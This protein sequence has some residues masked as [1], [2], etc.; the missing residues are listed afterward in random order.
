MGRPVHAGSRRRDVG[1]YR[2]AMAARLVLRADVPAAELALARA[3]R[4]DPMTAWLTGVEDPAAREAVARF[5]F[6][7]PGLAA[8]F[9][10]GH[11][12]V[13]AGEEATEPAGDPVLGG[14]AVWSPP[15]VELFG[16]AEGAAFA[17]AL[18]AACGESA[19]ERLMALAVAPL[20]P[21][22]VGC[23]GPR[24]RCGQRAAPAGARTLRRRRPPRIPRIVERSQRVILRAPRVPG[25]VGGGARRRPDAARHVARAG[26]RSRVTAAAEGFGNTQWGTLVVPAARHSRLERPWPP[27]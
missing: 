4:D 15:D 25:A 3:F 16:E 24:P 8:G 19:I 21:V 6:F 20:L 12:Y 7:A 9:P 13:V 17:T 22:P 2:P 27:N 23:G 11:C 26:H 1:H 18:V 10:R 5:G 14:A